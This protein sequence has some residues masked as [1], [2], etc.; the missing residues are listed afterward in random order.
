M[1]QYKITRQS[2]QLHIRAYVYFSEIYYTVH[3]S[4][5]LLAISDNKNGISFAHLPS[6]VES[7]K[8]DERDLDPNN[9]TRHFLLPLQ[10]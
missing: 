6:D 10:S 4:V 8:S 1:S 2:T 7:G 5:E 3:E 9:L